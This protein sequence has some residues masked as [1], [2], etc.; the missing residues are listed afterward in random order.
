MPYFHLSTT[1]KLRTTLFD[2]VNCR[3]ERASHLISCKTQFP[4]E[5]TIFSVI[6]TATTKM[7]DIGE[8]V[9]VENSFSLKMLISHLDTICCDS[10]YLPF[11]FFYHKLQTFIIVER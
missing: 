10:A 1:Q 3:L 6:V 7:K 11:E 4:F 8:L 2:V 5:D 9:A